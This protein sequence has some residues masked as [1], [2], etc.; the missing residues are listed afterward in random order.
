LH[1]AID[2]KLKLHSLEQSKGGGIS[3]RASTGFLNQKFFMAENLI[4]IVKPKVT[5]LDILINK[6]ISF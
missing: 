4:Q 3:N 1:L 5:E 6:M 2:P